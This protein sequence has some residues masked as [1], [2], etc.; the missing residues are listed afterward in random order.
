MN[1]TI[2]G[3][4]LRTQSST[5]CN[6]DTTATTALTNPTASPVISGGTIAGIVVGVVAGVGLLT[7]GMCFFV[8]RK[9]MSGAAKEEGPQSMVMADQ[10]AENHVPGEESKLH[11]HTNTTYSSQYGEDFS[12]GIWNASE[13]SGTP[14]EPQRF[15]LG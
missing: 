5:V 3:G 13:L 11:S 4:P 1:V 10:L 7:L 14:R 6:T 2:K 9:K 15:E 8:R 12:P